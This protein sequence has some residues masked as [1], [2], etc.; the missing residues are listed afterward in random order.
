MAF[1]AVIA[2]FQPI[3]AARALLLILLVFREQFS[4]IGDAARDK[5]FRKAFLIA[6]I[7]GGAI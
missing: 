7:V 5:F 1:E 4:A 2:H 3:L 6:K